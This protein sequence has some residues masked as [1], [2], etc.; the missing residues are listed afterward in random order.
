MKDFFKFMFASMLGF[1]LTMLILFFLFMGMALTLVSLTK[2]EDVTVNNKTC[3]HLKLDYQIEDRTS[4]T[5]LN[6]TFNFDILKKVMG[7]NDIL[8]DI[9]KAKN[10]DRIQGIYL[11]LMDIPSGLSTITEIRDALLDFK[12]SG[13]FVYTY[14]DVLTQ[15]AYYLASASD[16]IYMNPVGVL[17]FKGF[18]AEGVFIK[19]LLDKLDIKPQII[20]H[21]K[22]KSAVEPLIMEKMS[23]ANKEQTQT[24]VNA[25]WNKTVDDISAA[26]NLSK[27]DLNEIADKLSASNVENA[28]ALHLI[29]SVIY[30]DEFLSL[31]AEKIGVDLVKKDNLISLNSYDN[32]KVPNDGKSRSRNKIAVIYASGDIVEGEGDEQT[33]GSDK[34]ARTIRNARLD[35]SIKAIV[36]RVNSPGGDGLA[37]DVILREVTLAKEIKPVVVSMGNLAASGGYY[38][39][40]G[41]N[42]I[43]ANKNT[44]TGSIGVFGVIPNFQGFFNNKLGI[45]FDGVK[46]NENSDFMRVT[47]PLSEFQYNVIHKE[48]EHF[49]TTF[50]KH[51]SEGRNMT[52]AEVDSIGQGRV[53]AGSDALKNGLVDEIGGLEQ[54]IKAASDLAGLPDYRT[55]ELPEQEDPFQQLLNTLL[56]ETHLKLMEKELGQNFKYYTFLKKVSEMK[57]VQARLPFELEIN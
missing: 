57:G 51:V 29:D 38:I 43:F 52:F 21:G 11:D 37:S 14:A 3:L 35:E 18:N 13:K 55:I 1:F 2:T 40:C 34:I 44:I 22:Y 54:A 39:S 48:I 28:T 8:K 30:Y 7:L 42:K 25:L 10:D 45:T 41:A 36:L 5:P 31:L 6:F 27:N 12:T 15:K 50:V 26:R 32:A 24:F 56:G 47:K 23:E 53:W 33:I 16:K 46:T 49:Y 19:G 9:E 17:E 20:R 4:T